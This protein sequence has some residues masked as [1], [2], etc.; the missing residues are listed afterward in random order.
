MWKSLAL[1]VHAGEPVGLDWSR[2]LARDV[3]LRSDVDILLFNFPCAT[4][5]SVGWLCLEAWLLV[6][7]R[8]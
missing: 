2:D 7:L 8:G 3:A 5:L 1:S 4:T 6:R